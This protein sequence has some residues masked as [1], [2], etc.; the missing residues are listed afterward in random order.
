MTEMI[1]IAW[2]DASRSSQTLGSQYYSPSY[3]CSEKLDL[4]EP[5]AHPRSDKGRHGTSV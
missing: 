1:G 4:G 3:P 5:P 2:F